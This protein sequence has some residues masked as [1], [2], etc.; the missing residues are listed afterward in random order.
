MSIIL[1]CTFLITCLLLL[2]SPKILKERDISYFTFTAPAPTTIP[3]KGSSQS[4]VNP[5]NE[6]I[7]CVTQDK[8][9]SVKAINS[10]AIQLK[11]VRSE[12]LCDL[13]HQEMASP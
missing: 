13:F 8:P 4:A 5:E 2:L 11:V 6:D 1:D 3:G 9:V 12:L 10:K 7:H